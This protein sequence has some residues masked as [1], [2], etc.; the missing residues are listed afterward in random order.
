[1]SI[2]NLEKRIEALEALIASS[3]LTYK[4]DNKFIIKGLDITLEQLVQRDDAQTTLI[5]LHNF[6]VDKIDELEDRIKELED[7][8]DSR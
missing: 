8:E 3:Q 7:L 2:E 1:M 6:M 4:Y 5:K